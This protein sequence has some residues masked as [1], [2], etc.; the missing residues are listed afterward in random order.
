MTKPSPSLADYARRQRIIDLFGQVRT[1]LGIADRSLMPPVSLDDAER[2]ASF[3]LDAIRTLKA[4]RDR[5]EVEP[6][7]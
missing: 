2:A 3:A 7:P 6:A 4:V 1:Q 5:Q